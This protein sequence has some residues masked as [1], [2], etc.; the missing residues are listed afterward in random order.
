MDNQVIAEFEQPFMKNG[1]E[2]EAIEVMECL[3]QG[4]KE[5]DKVR[6]TE[7]VAVMEILDECR[8][9]VGLKFDF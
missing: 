4:K 9:Q 2:Y 7:S 1:Y 3:C 5:S 8:R 6:L